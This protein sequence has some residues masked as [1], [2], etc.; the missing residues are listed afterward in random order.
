MLRQHERHQSQSADDFSDQ[1]KFSRA[2]VDAANSI[3]SHEAAGKRLLLNVTTGH[4]AFAIRQLAASQIAL[5]ITAPAIFASEWIEGTVARSVLLIWLAFAAAMWLLR[6]VAYLRLSRAPPEELAASTRMRIVPLAIAFVAILFWTISN[7]LFVNPDLNPGILVLFT[8][9]VAMS[10]PMAGVFLVSPLSAALSIVALW[11]VL[12]LRMWQLDT[13]SALEASIVGALIFTALAL[14]IFHASQMRVHL[15]R[16][17]RVDLLVS[18][19]KHANAELERLRNALSK[20]LR[21]KSTFFA[22]ANHDFKQHLH[23]LKMAAGSAAIAVRKLQPEGEPVVDAILRLNEHVE[24][25]DYYVSTILDFARIETQQ[26]EPQLAMVAMQD[27]F[28]DIGVGFEDAA[29]A[30][31]R[32][33][34]I[35]GSR[36]KLCTDRA[37]LQRLLENLVANAI[38]FTRAGVLLGARWRSG[39]L[40]IQVWDQGPGIDPEQQAEIFE[41]FYQAR[42]VEVNAS[43]RPGIGL[44]LAV[45]KRFAKVLGYQVT[46]RSRPGK[47]SL[48]E[49]RIPAAAILTT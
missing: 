42:N 13:L 18:D 26:E 11:G 44:G 25:L 36:A 49:I 16:S 38:K 37:M 35:R 29:L 41:A 39:D 15:D 1:H 4:R 8:G 32:T 48:F 19:L 12:I 46:V 45:T 10:I 43:A 28:Q 21:R 31:D 33:L 34:K 20:D 40:V 22:S 2:Q 7:Y 23:G 9:Y 17:D 30:A 5:G 27:I 24:A 6:S 47:G 3:V 14:A